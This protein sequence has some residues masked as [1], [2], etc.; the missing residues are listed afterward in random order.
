[1][2]QGPAVVAVVESVEGLATVS[3]GNT[4]GNL[5]K[6]QKIVNGA[7]VVTTS[8]GS[9]VLKFN[10]G[11]VISLTPNQAVTID[12]ERECKALVAG[13]QSTGALAFAAGAGAGGSGVAAAFLGGTGIAFLVANYGSGKPRPQPASGS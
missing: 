4:L 11:C 2:A 3:Q 13:I 8:T 7:R 5:V 10:N 6:D 1:M 12:S 9:A